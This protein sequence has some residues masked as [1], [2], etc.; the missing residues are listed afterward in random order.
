MKPRKKSERSHVL[1]WFRNYLGSQEHRS[2]T[3]DDEIAIEIEGEG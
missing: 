1:G 3:R 2:T